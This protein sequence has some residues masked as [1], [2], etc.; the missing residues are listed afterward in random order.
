MTEA[1]GGGATGQSKNRGIC[2]VARYAEASRFLTYG[3]DIDAEG[4]VRDRTI[5]PC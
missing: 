4:E 2:F 5:V 3:L 1:H